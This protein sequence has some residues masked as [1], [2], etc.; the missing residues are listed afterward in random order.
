MVQTIFSA[1]AV[2]ISTSIDYFIII[3]VIFAQA[4]G[5][6]SEI[7][8]II[9]GQYVGTAI[10]VIVS[11]V[12]AYIANFIPQGWIIGLLG[13]IPL[14]LGVRMLL[15]HEREE[16]VKEAQAL[17][18]RFNSR[19]AL[20]LIWVVA[21]IYIAAGGDNIGIYI[22]Y[23]MTLAV[24]HIVL[25]II[26]FALALALFSWVCYRLANS[27]LI[28]EVVEKTERWLVPFVFIGLGVYILTD[29]GTVAF[30]LQSIQ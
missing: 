11:L 2:F 8:Q 13:L 19:G 24:S 26:V 28:I 14:Y 27:S 4:A 25:A 3:T 29:N 15:N 22:P 18:N 21:A 1:L 6:S 7:R 9:I 10:L 5:S 12:A 17:L 30:I 23:F 16:G 20:N